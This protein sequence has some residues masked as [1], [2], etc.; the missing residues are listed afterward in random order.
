VP[1]GYKDHMPT[2]NWVIALHFI[3]LWGSVLTG[4][5][6]GWRL[7]LSNLVAIPLGLL[8]WAA[9]LLFNIYVIQ[10]VRNSPPM[11][12]SEMTGRSYQR[13]TAR[14]LMNLGLGLLFRSWL[15]LIVAILLIPFYTAASRSRRRYLDYMRTGMQDDAFPDRMQKS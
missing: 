2:A 15:T 1:R 11:R 7:P 14:T 12:R 5:L 4:L 6:A 8:L 10:R 9:G 3:A 13:I